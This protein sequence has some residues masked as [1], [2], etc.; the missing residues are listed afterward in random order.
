MRRREFIAGLGGAAACSVGWRAAR[1]QQPVFVVGYLSANFAESDPGKRDFLKGLT[2]AGFTE[3]HNVAIEY[4]YAHLAFAQL[5]QLAADLLHRRVDVIAAE[6]N[7]ATEAA[8]AATA[9]VPIVFSIGGDPVALGLVASLSRPGANL[10]GASFLATGTTAKMVEVLHE[11]VPAAPI[12]ALFNPAN[13]TSESETRE[14]QRAASIIGVKLDVFAAREERDINAVFETLLE[15]H[16]GGL[17]IQGDP[18]F[19]T[20]IKQFVALTLRHSIP[21]IYQSSDFVEA[22]GLM[23]YGGSLGEASRL[24]GFYVGRILKGEKPADLPV[25]QSTRLETV[26]NLKTARALGITFPTPLLVRADEVI[27]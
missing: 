27:E 15:H 7:A 8:K 4:R 9:T 22:G 10:T 23:S 12:A 1:A 25:Q 6:F 18:L 3:G 19:T 20:Q 5:P 24:A 11:V 16:T 21:A 14:T 26:L 13:P 2:E 17:V